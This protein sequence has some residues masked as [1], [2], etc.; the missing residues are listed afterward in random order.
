MAQR[1]LAV[2]W[3]LLGH[4]FN[5][6]PGTVGWG[7]SLAAVADYIATMA[8]ISSLAWDLHMLW[9]AQNDQKKKNKKKNHPENLSS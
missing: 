7:S 9:V 4:R 1:E 2:S 3:E 5:P 8:L 6:W